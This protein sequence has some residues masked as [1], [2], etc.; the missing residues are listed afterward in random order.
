MQRSQPKRGIP[1][2]IMLSLAALLSL[3]SCPPAVSQPL[4]QQAVIQVEGE[5]L[6][7][8][9]L[10]GS[11]QVRLE[12]AA[13]G[14]TPVLGFQALTTPPHRV[15]LLLDTGATSHLLRR[16]A[17]ERLGLASTPIPEGD[18]GFSGAGDHCRP[19]LAKGSLPPLRLLGDRGS[20]RLEG[21]ETVILPMAGLPEGVD[22]VLGAPALRQLPLWVDPIAGSVGFGARALQLADQALGQRAAQPNHQHRLQWKHGA[23]ITEMQRNNGARVAA[24]VDT[25]AEGIFITPELAGTL[26]WGFG[27]PQRIR[28]TG[29]CGIQNAVRAKLGGLVLD[30]P[31]A[32]Q[33]PQEQSV[34]ITRNP[35]FEDLGVELIVGQGWLR[36]RRQLW[37]LDEKPPVLRL[38]APRLPKRSPPSETG[39]GHPASRGV[40]GA[41]R[42]PGTECAAAAD[43]TCSL[44]WSGGVAP[45]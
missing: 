16:S 44:L 2:G 3:A 17:S 5:E 28:V 23:P 36:H 41:V 27:P 15:R 39:A 9:R 7:A 31:S 10:S 1:G 33:A 18:V 32:Q 6:A 34:I 24:L 25:G 11:G 40:H 35:V 30:Q 12:R 42:V 14:D 43:R 19:E 22:G 13:A 45:E 8:G 21:A 29:F 26:D 4:R 38:D 37:R 20:V